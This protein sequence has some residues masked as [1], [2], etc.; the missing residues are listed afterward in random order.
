MYLVV[1]LNVL[2]FQD[3]TRAYVDSML[4]I[5]SIFSFDEF[6][7]WKLITKGYRPLLLISATNVPFISSR[8]IPLFLSTFLVSSAYLFVLSGS[9]TDTGNQL[10]HVYIIKSRKHEVLYLYNTFLRNFQSTWHRRQS[11][12]L[13][14]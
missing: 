7:V 8:F 12:S 1:L 10:R 9:W 6:L 13:I 14:M 2:P 11:K 3:R 5:L 4:L